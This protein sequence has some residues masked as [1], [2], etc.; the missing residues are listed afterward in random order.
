MVRPVAQNKDIL[1][2]GPFSLV[3]S[4]R[5]LMKDG[6]PVELGARTLDTLI[7]LVSCPTMRSL[8]RKI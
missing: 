1:S 7:A 6:A 4:E 5:L 2:F 8:A 3:A